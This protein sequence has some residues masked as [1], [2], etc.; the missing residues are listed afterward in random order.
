M[1]FRASVT[2]LLPLYAIGVFLSFT[3]SQAGMARRWWRCG[4]LA[5]GE[6]VVDPGSVLRYDSN[7]RLKMTINMVG[8]VCTCVVMFVFAITKFQ[9]GAWIIVLL[10]PALVF[11]FFRIHHHYKDL[12]AHLSLDQF[13]ASPRSGR[14]RV[15][16][17]IGGV[18]RGTMAALSYARALSDDVTA[19]YVSIDPIESEKVRRKWETW[20]EGVRLIVLDSPYRLLIE[21]V[22]EYLEKVTPVQQPNETLTIVIPQFVPRVA[23]HNLLHSQTALMLRLALLFKPGVVVTEV[24]YQIL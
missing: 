18:H 7:W 20:G 9:D 12:A 10:V 19:V 6:E 21:P 8:A 5:P 22:L 23:W 1:L 4:R 15:V 24:P 13:G 16:L 3:L 17:L 2:A 11:L 14:H